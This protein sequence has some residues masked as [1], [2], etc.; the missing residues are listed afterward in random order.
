MICLYPY[1][2]RCIISNIE[3]TQALE[4]QKETEVELTKYIKDVLRLSVTSLPEANELRPRAFHMLG[5]SLILGLHFTETPDS[6]LV[7]L[8]ALLAELPGG[9]ISV[10][11]LSRSKVVRIN[12]TA[13][14]FVDFMDEKTL[15][16]YYLY[17]SGVPK[18]YS[19]ILN[20]ERMLLINAVLEAKQKSP[21]NPAK[22]Q[23]ITKPTEKT[24]ASV[25]FHSRFYSKER[26]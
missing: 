8:P 14:S 15:R 18:E 24:F 2:L 10:T 4:P 23:K 3:E 12:K 19:D 20:P 26:H 7:G 21:S 6:F 17:L 16:W 13:S 25:P 5:G 9:Q 1:Y 11:S 22:A